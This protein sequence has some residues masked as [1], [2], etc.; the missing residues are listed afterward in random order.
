[1][2]NK[3]NIFMDRTF[4]AACLMKANEKEWALAIIKK[5]VA[6]YPDDLPRIKQLFGFYGSMPNC[7]MFTSRTKYMLEHRDSLK[8]RYK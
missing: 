4:D 8:L 6:T 2:R 1:M 3:D 5:L 7:D